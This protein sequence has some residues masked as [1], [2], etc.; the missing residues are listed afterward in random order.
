MIRAQLNLHAVSDR[1]MAEII[2][3]NI[4]HPVLC[5]RPVPA[6]SYFGEPERAPLRRGPFLE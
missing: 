5:H 6:G 4:Q 1:V 2:K 3:T